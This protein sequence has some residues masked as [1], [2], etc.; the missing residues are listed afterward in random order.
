LRVADETKL[1][2]QPLIAIVDDDESVRQAVGALVRSLGYRAIVFA[3][4]EQLL[5]SRRR[6]EICCV[7]ADI[8]M[9][10]L[11]GLELHQQLT[12]SE[13]PIPTILITA[14]PDERMRRRA[15]TL[16]VTCYLTKPFK[17]DDLIK[18]LSWALAAGGHQNHAPIGDA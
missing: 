15:H 16:G 12:A 14:Y 8:Q 7:I 1:P 9:P 4:A 5:T 6:G 18:C 3:G 11:S 13:E 10:G 17:E 2:R